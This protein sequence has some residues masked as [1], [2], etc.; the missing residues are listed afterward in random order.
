MLSRIAAPNWSG[1]PEASVP[2]SNTITILVT[3][4]VDVIGGNAAASS[5]APQRRRNQALLAAA[6]APGGVL[7]PTKWTVPPLVTTSNLGA[8]A[9]LC[10]PRG[11]PEMPPD[12]PM[13]YPR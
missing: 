7:Q 9:P 2:S 5:T 10:D 1:P 12:S 8:P 6:T 3:T 4:S 13:S 11:H